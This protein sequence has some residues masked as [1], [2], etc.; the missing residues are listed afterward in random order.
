MGEE[1]TRMI[2]VREDAQGF[3][4][5]QEAAV[6]G[7]KIAGE[8]R[9]RVEIGTGEKVVSETNYLDLKADKTQ[10]LPTNTDSL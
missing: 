5:N 1:T 6:R 9:E 3:N 10:E 2:A 4:D 7:G 8:A